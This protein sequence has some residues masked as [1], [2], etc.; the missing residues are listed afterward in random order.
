MPRISSQA[1]NTTY[2]SAPLFQR[3]KK[4]IVLTFVLL[5]HERGFQVSLRAVPGTEVTR[6]PSLTGPTSG[7]VTPAE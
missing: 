7:L 6:T 2:C 1:E 5:P 3:K 4:Y